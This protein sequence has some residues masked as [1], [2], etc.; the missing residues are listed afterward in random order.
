MKSRSFAIGPQIGYNFNI[1]GVPIYTNLRAYY[2][3]A[4]ENR[5]EGG[6]VFLTINVPLSALGK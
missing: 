4:V 6:S 5:T 3:F 1:G 2:E